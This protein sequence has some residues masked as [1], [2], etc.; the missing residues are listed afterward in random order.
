MKASFLSDFGSL[1]NPKGSQAYE[2]SDTRVLRNLP[3]IISTN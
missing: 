1:V 3:L 2:G